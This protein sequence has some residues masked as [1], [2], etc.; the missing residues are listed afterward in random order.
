LAA[1]PD[2]AAS[3]HESFES[4]RTTRSC[5]NL[6]SCP[7]L[8]GSARE[9]AV[10]RVQGGISKARSAFSQ[11]LTQVEE[12]WTNEHLELRL[13]VLGQPLS[14]TMDVADDHVRLEVMLPWLLGLLG[15][16]TKTLIEKQGQLMLEKK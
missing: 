15:E 7:F 12:T 16:R 10:R 11:H 9:E 13:A 8:I 2:A 14:G 3:P 6:S 5:Q 4:H 1:F